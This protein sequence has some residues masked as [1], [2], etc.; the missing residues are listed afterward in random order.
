MLQ[1]KST[2][3]GQKGLL[4]A[5]FSVLVKISIGKMNKIGGGVL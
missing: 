5:V 1:R 3:R 4:E 2:S